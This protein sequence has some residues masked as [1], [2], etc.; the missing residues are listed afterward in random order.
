[1]GCQRCRSGYAFC[2]AVGGQ[3][4]LL[5]IEHSGG[6]PYLWDESTT[7]DRRETPQT[8]GCV[9]QSRLPITDPNRNQI[10]SGGPNG[11]EPHK[12]FVHVLA[13][14][15]QPSVT[16]ADHHIDP[17]QHL[18][19]SR[20]QITGHSP[21]LQAYNLHTR[22]IPRLNPTAF[23]AGAPTSN[24][25]SHPRHCACENKPICWPESDR[26]CS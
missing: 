17:T 16:S 5:R 19:P 25:H 7:V 4:S 10:T 15:P 9:K 12:V 2:F 11:G 20:P 24:M 1:M 14:I 18:R 22:R 23:F 13:P 21:G 3:K 6:S 8:R 26:A